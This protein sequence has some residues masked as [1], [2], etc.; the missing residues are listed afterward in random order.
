M[1]QNITKLQFQ[2]TMQYTVLHNNY[3][4]QTFYEKHHFSYMNEVTTGCQTSD[5]DLPANVWYERSEKL[6]CHPQ[7]QL[8][9]HLSNEY[10]GNS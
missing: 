10:R 7:R 2:N 1:V 5:F 6:Q 9:M 3:Y 8:T 4:F